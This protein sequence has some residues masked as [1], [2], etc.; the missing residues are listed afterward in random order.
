MVYAIWNSRVGRPIKNIAHDAAQE[1]I[2]SVQIY[3]GMTSNEKKK[4]EETSWIHLR[5]IKIIIM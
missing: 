4:T 1:L 2:K 5:T 3:Y